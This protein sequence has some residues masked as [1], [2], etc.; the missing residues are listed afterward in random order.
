MIRCLLL[1][2]LLATVSFNGWSEPAASAPG[3]DDGC[4]TPGATA[5][6][7][8]RHPAETLAFFQVHPDSSVLELTPGAGWYSEI[9][10]PILKEKGR[11][12]AAVYAPMEAPEAS[13]PL[14]EALRSRFSHSAACFSRAEM[15]LFDIRSPRLGEAD[16]F[17][18]VL[19]F[20]NVHNWEDSETLELMLGEALRVLRPGGVLG[21]V[22]HRADGPYHQELR[23]A[24][25]YVRTARVV[26]VAR[27]IGFV[28]EESSEINANPV[29]TKNYPNG[30]WSLPPT[31]KGG[32]VDRQKYMSIGESDRMTLRFRK[33]EQ[34]A[35]QEHP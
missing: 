6:D 4:R 9:L 10:A 22:D 28:L 17:D 24:T 14:L 23:P 7:R 15:A 2:C 29:D 5:R 8:F 20:R 35:L 25:G 33:P 1:G 19:T 30:V 12:V 27:K 11:Y 18:V 26:D 21:V 31:L 3:F 32:D 13:N 34:A 16:T